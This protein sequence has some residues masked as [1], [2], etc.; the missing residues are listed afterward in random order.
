MKSLSTSWSEESVLTQSFLPMSYAVVIEVATPF[1]FNLQGLKYNERFISEE[2]LR[3][4][5]ICSINEDLIK[6]IFRF[7]IGCVIFQ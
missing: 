1:K 5:Q 4:K 6:N 2:K 7:G 3:W